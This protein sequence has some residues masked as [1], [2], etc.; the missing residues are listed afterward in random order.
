MNVGINIRMTGY[1][2]KIN[3]NNNPGNRNKTARFF[4]DAQPF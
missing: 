3:I 2:N 1:I 4:K